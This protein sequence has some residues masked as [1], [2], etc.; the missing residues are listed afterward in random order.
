MFKLFKHKANATDILSSKLYN[1]QTFY[2]TFANDVRKA[3]RH[4]IIE[5]PFLTE[6]R[7]LQFCQQFKR[8][9]KRNVKITV[10]TRNPRHHDKSLEIQAWKAMRRLRDSGVKVHTYDDLRHRKLAVIDERILWEGSLNILSQN[11]HR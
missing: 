11:N 5:S 10:N 4:V 8:I 9:S 6:R 7:A 1:E 3:R 2:K